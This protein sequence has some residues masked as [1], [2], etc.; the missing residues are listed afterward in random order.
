MKLIRLFAMFILCAVPI[1]A[2]QPASKAT[3]S[4][5]TPAS[6]QAAEKASSDNYDWSGFEKKKKPKTS[7][8]SSPEKKAEPS[9]TSAAATSFNSPVAALKTGTV[10][11]RPDAAGFDQDYSNGQVRKLATV[12]G[13]T[14]WATLKYVCLGSANLCVTKMVAQVGVINDGGKRVDLL[15]ENVSL[16]LISPDYK[17]LPR[18][19]AQQIGSSLNKRAFWYG[20]TVTALAG[21]S[22]NTYVSTYR[23]PY[24]TSTL[25]TTTPDYSARFRAQRQSDEFFRAA[26][27]SKAT[28]GDLELKA[29]TIRAGEQHTRLVFFKY[30]KN[31]EE[32]LLTILL[33]GKEIQFP[34]RFSKNK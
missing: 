16:E 20:L 23:S 17:P 25:V 29:Q 32:T 5:Y 8:A 22:T 3:E 2:Q 1:C 28:L 15:P 11:W 6:K 4:H 10:R 31:P 14:V 7:A 21:L 26:Q 9:N 24:G 19:T 13:V 30:E 34:F 18:E 33:N 27:V 12:D